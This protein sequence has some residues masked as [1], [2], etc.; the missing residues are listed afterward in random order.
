MCYPN[1]FGSHFLGRAEID[2]VNPHNFLGIKV[3]RIFRTLLTA[4]ASIALALGFAV[5]PANATSTVTVYTAT[6]LVAGQLNAAA[7]TVTFTL[8]VTSA[9]ATVQ[10][11]VMN[12]PIVSALSWQYGSPAVCTGFSSDLPSSAVNRCQSFAGGNSAVFVFGA[13]N[14]SASGTYTIT[15]APGTFTARSTGSSQTFLVDL[16]ESSPTSIGSGTI[17][18]GS[19]GTPP[20]S[21]PTPTPTPSATSTPT[22][23]A[24]P[25]VGTAA[26]LAELPKASTQPKLKFDSSANGLGKSAKKSLKKVAEVAK[27]GYGVRVTGAAGMQPGVSKDVVKALA[28]KRAMEI[29]AYLIKQG[30][31][32]EDIIIKTK[33]FPIGKAPATLVKVETLS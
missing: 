18:F 12:G 14:V 7:V 31:P 10:V 13:Q 33:I 28:K 4:F 6:P 1:I 15:L 17:N 21:T 23:A 32:K 25:A 9:N 16:L 2:V 27:D 26:A 30:V 24:T 22:A 29:R 5:S 11:Q 3:N 8:P 20:S 19:T